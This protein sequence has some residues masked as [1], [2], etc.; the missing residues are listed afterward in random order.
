MTKQQSKRLDAIL[1]RFNTAID[2]LAD[3]RMSLLAKWFAGKFPKHSLRIIFGNGDELVLVDGHTIHLEDGRD[4]NIA[5]DSYP[6]ANGRYA[7][8]L[9]PIHDAL[10]DVW[11]IT[12]GYRRGCPNDVNVNNA[13]RGKKCV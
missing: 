5:R 8:C 4:V 12:D 10:R 9:N 7:A 2:K 13:P 6:T 3:E 11:E 1:D